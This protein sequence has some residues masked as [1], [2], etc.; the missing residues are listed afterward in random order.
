MAPP[1]HP[2]IP[3]CSYVIFKLLELMFG[4]GYKLMEVVPKPHEIFV[5][6]QFWRILQEKWIV[7]SNKFDVTNISDVLHF[8]NECVQILI[9][10]LKASGYRITCY[11]GTSN[12]FKAQ[13]ESMTC[14]DV[15]K[16]V[17]TDTTQ[18]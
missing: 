2:S 13:V 8:R 14:A 1:P 4:G 3:F 16:I 17:F 18:Y 5:R 15:F 9:A 12:G 6:V 7:P 11:E 10:D